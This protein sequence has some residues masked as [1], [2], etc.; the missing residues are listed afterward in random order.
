MG[1]GTV[2]P[3]APLHIKAWNGA[4]GGRLMRLESGTATG[5]GLALVTSVKQANPWQIFGT[6][7]Q[8]KIGEDG[9]AD[10][11]TFAAGTGNIGIG[12]APV[13]SAK[14]AVNGTIKATEI[15][16]MNP[17]FADYVFE[18]GYRLRPLGEVGS[19]FGR[20]IICRRFRRRRRWGRMGWVW[21]RCRRSCWRRLR[22]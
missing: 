14:L 19:L 18:A 3:E 1:I 16:V 11:M 20:I 7:T 21:G 4:D 2:A 12:V 10:W 22:N 5:A 13:A 17:P 8:L 6:G 9:V 15:V